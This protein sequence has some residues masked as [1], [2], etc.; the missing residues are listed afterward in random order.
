MELAMARV[1]SGLSNGRM[2]HSVACL[3]GT[4]E[5]AGHLPASTDIHCMH[6]R[7]NEPQLPFRLGRLVRQ[8]RP[9]LVHARNWG[10]WP[11]TAAARML[12]EPTLP[13]ILSFHGLGKAGY[14]P[15]RRRL[16]TWVLARVA[17]RLFAVSGQS[18]ELMIAKWG[19]PR[20]K[21]DVIPNGV[22]T[23]R[24]RP[25]DRDRNGNRV[26]VGTVGNLRPVKNHALLVRACGELAH[27]GCDLELRIAG[28]GEER[29]NLV[30]LAESVGLANRLEL[31]GRVE[32]VPGFLHKLDV[33]VLSS[34]S[35][36]HP[37]ALNEAM[38]CGLPCVATRVGC[39]EELLDGGRC[40]KIVAPGNVDQMTA[41]VG[42]LISGPARSRRYASAGRRRACE[43]YSLN[44]MLLA[45]DML[46]TRLSRR[47]KR[48]S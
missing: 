33:F 1:V 19:W 22:D 32:N 24:F 27:R 42:E 35:E 4:P 36:Q 18:R 11:D 28:E 40:G 10:A 9:D 47:R 2:R 43:R 46:Y 14:M 31:A 37:N 6:A 29:T 48:Q 39:V 41:A 15:L 8:I 45:Y 44:N 13:L 21:A 25:A 3:T 5:I 12:V 20:W 17:T 26:I 34:D 30:A 16:A 7:S 38:A 23:D